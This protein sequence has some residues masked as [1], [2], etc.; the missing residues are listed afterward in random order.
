MGQSPPERPA[1]GPGW[2]PAHL[3]LPSVGVVIW[4]LR[5][6][7]CMG[8]L[9]GSCPRL[10]GAAPPGLLP[11]HSSQYRE[12]GRAG[13]LSPV[14]GPEGLRVTV[15]VASALEPG[16]GHFRGRPPCPSGPGHLAKS[17][18]FRDKLVGPVSGAELW[19]G[20]AISSKQS[21]GSACRSTL[22]SCRKRRMFR[23]R[24]S[25]SALAE[26]LALEQLLRW[27]G[28]TPVLPGSLAH[29]SGSARWG[30][31]RCPQG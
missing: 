27:A 2:S 17:G 4:L 28:P 29:P 1:W 21:C 23:A 10:P 25:R 3:C 31:A 22:G 18:A 15:H 9:Q 11:P 16:L 6:G 20:A 26:G 13:C 14:S 24:C 5:V 7:P 12:T 19:A 8:G 30:E